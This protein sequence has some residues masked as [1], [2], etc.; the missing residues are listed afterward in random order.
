MMRLAFNQYKVG[1]IP[2]RPF[3]GMEQWLAHLAHNQE[4]KRFDSSPCH[5][6]L[7]DVAQLEELLSCKQ[8]VAGS[9]PVI[10]FDASQYLISNNANVM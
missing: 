7:A 6:F 8:M 5:H 3:A 1:S 10:S 4:I 9:I 2:M